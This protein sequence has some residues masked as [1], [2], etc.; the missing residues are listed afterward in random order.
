MVFCSG[1]AG[2]SGIRFKVSEEE[3][4]EGHQAGVLQRCSKAKAL[5]VERVNGKG[6]QIIR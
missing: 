1:L 6:L 2:Q 5:W 3:F 4:E